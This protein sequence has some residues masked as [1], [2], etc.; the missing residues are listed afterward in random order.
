MAET[1]LS[2]IPVLPAIGM[3]ETEPPTVQLTICPYGDLKL[4]LQT[5][6]INTTYLVSS[7]LLCSASPVFRASLGP[8]S[9]FADAI[10]LRRSQAAAT[11]VSDHALYNMPIGDDLGFDPTAMAVVLY[12]IHGRM[13]HIPETIEFGNLLD[14]AL[15]CDYFDCAVTMSPWNKAWMQPLEHLVL[16][17]GYE[18]WLFVAFVFG[19]QELF[20]KITKS[21]TRN[22]LIANDGEFGVMVNN[23]VKKMHSHLPAGITRDMATNREKAG[24]DV[25][26]VCQ[27]MYDT[28][29]DNSTVKCL[30]SQKYCDSIVFASLH[31]DLGALGLLGDEKKQ[32]EL[33]CTHASRTLDSIIGDITNLWISIYQDL[34]N[35]VIKGRRHP[36]CVLAYRQGKNFNACLDGI[37]SL[38]LASYAKSKIPDENVI[39]DSVVGR[40]CIPRDITGREYFAPYVSYFEICPY[41]DLEIDYYSISTTFVVSSH[42]LR[43]ASLVFRNLLGPTSDF[44]EHSLRCKTLGSTDNTMQRY[45]L[46]VDMVHNP[47]VVAVVFYMLHGM[48]NKIPNEIE[49]SYLYDLAVVCEDYKCVSFVLP[50]CRN[51]LDKWTIE[52]ER[53][54]GWLYI[55]WVFGFEDIFQTLSGKFATGAFHAGNGRYVTLENEEGIK[56]LGENIPQMVIESFNERVAPGKRWLKLAKICMNGTAT[57]P[58]PNPFIP[59]PPIATPPIA[60]FTPIIAI[61]SRT[62]T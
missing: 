35:V 62:P 39:W 59:T 23:E 2:T 12:V 10:E 45:R 58:T 20:G 1:K 6:A 26:H 5:P 7:H 25:I 44:A 31:M 50:L 46:L 42:A 3:G 22:G 57:P 24:R 8:S 17:P 29:H 51:W 34:G 56:E 32:Y 33:P 13:E 43:T 47:S 4:S 61:T 48:R 36:S 55:A 21:Y 15:I 18:D 30:S 27:Q 52:K 54:G 41:G 40:N 11:S 60:S 9:G 49:L 19:N 16:Q 38:S 14:V 28:Y 53:Y 37:A